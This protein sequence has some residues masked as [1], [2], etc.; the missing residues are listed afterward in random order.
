MSIKFP[1]FQVLVTRSEQVP[2]RPARGTSRALQAD[3]P[4]VSQ[5]LP[6]RSGVSRGSARRIAS[7]TAETK[8][9]KTGQSRVR[10]NA[11]SVRVQ[12]GGLMCGPR[13]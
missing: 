7:V 5:S 4:Q 11:K 12:G 6:T 9:G 13:R 8:T 3:G 1:D 10:A 2:S